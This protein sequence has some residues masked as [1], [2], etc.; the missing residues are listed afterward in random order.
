MVLIVVTV[1]SRDWHRRGRVLV[2]LLLLRI[3]SIP[4]ELGRCLIA[5]IERGKGSVHLAVKVEERGRR[6]ATHD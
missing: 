1:V 5:I 6:A 2:L 3:L 4:A